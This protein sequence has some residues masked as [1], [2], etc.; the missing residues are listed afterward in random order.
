MRDALANQLSPPRLTAVSNCEAAPGAARQWSELARKP[1]ADTA[2]DDF[3]AGTGQFVRSNR[4]ARVEAVLLISNAAVTTRKLAQLA[5][6]ADAAEAKSLVEK[7]NH[8]YDNSNSSF[9]IERVAAG[10]RMLT[11]PELVFWLDRL[12][13]REARCR[14]TQSMLE[15]LTIVAYQQPITRADVEAIRGVAS[16]EMLKQ[17]MERGLVRIAGHDESLGRPYL[18]GTT[19]VFLELYGLKNLD[20]LP[21]ASELR[22]KK[23][24]PVSLD[25]AAAALLAEDSQ[26]A[27]GGGDE[28]GEPQL[29]D[30]DLIDE[31]AAEADE[32]AFDEDE[33]DDFE[34]EDEFEEAA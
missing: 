24:A 3:V 15:T 7:L 22:R 28:E 11:K 32:D 6:L 17:L 4:M 18:Y 33:D 16:T 5:T 26:S 20:D 8:A 34:G 9:R 31:E 29:D 25:Q 12:H 14:L 13:K 30:E 23:V 10:Y 1:I 19:R 27:A 2:V 21:M